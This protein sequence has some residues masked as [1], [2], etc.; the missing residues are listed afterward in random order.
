[1]KRVL[2]ISRE[3]SDLADL[4]C[5]VNPKSQII[6]P[7]DLLSVELDSFDSFALLGG[8]NED[9]MLLHPYIRQYFEEHASDVKKVFSEYCGSIGLYY[10]EKPQSNRYERLVITDDNISHD[11]SCGQILQKQ[12]ALN[13]PVYFQVEPLRH[14]LRCIPHIR[15]Y[16]QVQLPDAAKNEGSSALW[17]DSNGKKMYCT[18]QLCNFQK[19]RFSPRA[20]WR[21]LI[22]F[23]VNWLCGTNEMSLPFQDVYSLGEMDERNNSILVR[24]CSAADRGMIWYR[25][26]GILLDDGE[27]GVIE[28]VFSEIDGQGY[29]LLNKNLRADCWGESALPFYLRYLMHGN[30][31]D[32]RVS[33]NLINATF[34]GFYTSSGKFKGMMRWTWEGW[35]VCY[36]D[37]VARAILPVF[38]RQMYSGS[39][40]HFK[41]ALDA[42]DFLVM[43]TGSDGLRRMR[44][45]T[46]FLGGNKLND[47][48]SEPGECTSPN[49][50][51]YYAAALLL[52]GQLTNNNSYIEI[53]TKAISKVMSI[54]PKMERIQSETQ[55]LCRLIL[56]LAY[57]FGVTGERKHKEWLYKVTEDLAT[58]KHISGAYLEWDSGYSADLHD[59]A[60]GNEAAVFARNGDPLVDYLYSINWL[61]L[62]WINAYL[63]T[64]DSLFMKKWEEIA[65]FF[66]ITQISAPD[67]RINGAWTRVVDVDRMEVMGIP[68]DV[69]WG[70]WCIESG[71]TMSQITS[72]LYLGNLIERINSSTKKIFPAR[73]ASR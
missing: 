1:M 25:D 8:T 15:E 68:D 55:D 34:R 63:I 31:N 10:F 60:Q 21:S 29:Q 46:L 18:F 13:C 38:W 67:L 69:G 24:A 27:K 19:A 41:E 48:Q 65:N 54:Y 35:T 44:T 73:R 36:Q 53:A 56:P 59:A 37:D 43:T 64:D 72:G 6:N 58:M 57:L 32:L 71:W 28:G 49:H 39:S 30:A 4:L 23:I 7:D 14:L 5:W 45:D 66:A 47:L 9:P 2:I 20:R 62:A 22:T 3:Q 42:L 51:A 50:M 33:D 11:L 70:P 40:P 16:D 52:A 61:P 26:A 12:L 17:I